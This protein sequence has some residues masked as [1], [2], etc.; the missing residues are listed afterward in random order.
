MQGVS[1]FE[2]RYLTD[3]VND[4]K[5]SLA[6][7]DTSNK[8]VDSIQE[9]LEGMQAIW[10]TVGGIYKIKNIKSEVDTLDTKRI[11]TAVNELQGVEASYSKV[12]VI[13]SIERK[14]YKNE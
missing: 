2:V 9:T 6:T 14:S 13:T 5:R 7:F 1:E 12:M 8:S 4:K 10:N 3:L 11:A